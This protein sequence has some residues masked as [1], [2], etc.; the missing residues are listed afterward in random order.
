M[1]NDQGPCSVCPPGEGGTLELI[2]ETLRDG[3]QSLWGMMLS[4][5][6]FEPVL[7]EVAE[8]GFDT[9]NVA[10]HFG[11]PMLSTRFFKEDPRHLFAMG[12]EKLKDSP[13]NI[14]LTTLGCAVDITGA[15]QNATITRLMFEQFKEWI[16]S[17]NR[18]LVICCTEDE[19]QNQYPVLFPMMRKLG[20]EPVPYMA[21][22]HGPNHTEKFYASRVK[23]LVETFQPVSICIKDVDG[24][25]TPERLRRLIAAMQAESRGT[26]LE[27]HSHGMNGLN[28]YNATVAM[29]MGIRRITTCTPPLANGSSHPSVFDIVNNAEHMGISHNMD[30]EKLRVV[31]ERLA[32]I[33]KAYGHPV[34]N[35]HLPF[36]LQ[37]YQHQIPGGVISNTR[38]QLEALGIP[39][40][41]PEVLEEIPRVLED[42][43]HPIMITPFSQF[44]VTQAVMN[45]QVG[46]WEQCIDPCVEFAAGI[47]GYEEAGVAYMNQNIKDKLLSLPQAKPIIEKGAKMKDYIASEPS[48]AEVKASVGLPADA[49]R[50]DFVLR[51]LLRTDDELNNCTPGG[52]DAYKTYL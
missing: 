24:L 32:K 31:E 37:A 27:L 5:H 33:G 30:L 1:K 50:E 20:I 3:A 7:S 17:Y 52:P 16:P 29:D 23:K 46:R 51:Y 14:M 4:Y 45:T 36:D 26:P 10:F 47:Y 39:E 12:K 44:I 18:A 41:L 8:A 2:D 40:A 28:T 48:E 34:D 9:V 15:P 43:G 38:T 13:S 42:L 6:M 21:I 25:L 35:H 49:S 22:G 19:I 11:A